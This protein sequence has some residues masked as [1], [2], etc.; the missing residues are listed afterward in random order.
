MSYPGKNVRLRFLKFTVATGLLVFVIKYFKLGFIGKVLKLNIKNKALAPSPDDH[1]VF[2]SHK[3]PNQ[4]PDTWKLS[5]LYNTKVISEKMRK[6]LEE[7]D[8]FSVLI[9]VDDEILH[10]EYNKNHTSSSLLN[11]FSM[12]KGILALLVGCAIDDGYLESENICVSNFIKGYDQ[13]KLAENLTFKHL[14]CMQGGFDWDEEYQH[15]FA[16]NSE[17]YF[18]DDLTKQALETGFKN[19]PGELYEYQSVSAQILGIALRRVIKK[20]LAQY[21]SEKIWIPMGMELPAKWSVDSKGVEKAFCCIHACTRDF[22]KLGEMILKKG[23]WKNKQIISEEFIKRMLSPSDKN[24]AFCYSIWANDDNEITYR[25][26][27]G[28]LGQFIIMIPQKN[29]VIVKTG[30]YNKLKTDSKLRPTQVQMLVDEA[31]RLYG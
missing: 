11:S 24:D 17:Q 27:Y 20:D 23:K 3:I 22:A 12:A 30:F 21:L 2:T 4:H 10:E 18:I 1:E 9:T 26:F 29:M 13:N 7:T 19:R 14:M 6:E 8:T 31:I 28:F 16:E 15:P 5:H 25:F